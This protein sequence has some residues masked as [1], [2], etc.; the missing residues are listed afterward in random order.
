MLLTLAVLNR[1]VAGEVSVV[2]RRWTKPTVKEGGRLR[3]AVGELSI[4]GV[5]TVE[6]ASISDADAVLAGWTSAVE[7]VGDLFRERKAS[8]ARGRGAK[9]GGVRSIYWI[10]VS[11]AGADQRFD[12]RADDQLSDDELA[13]IVK[14]LDGH[15][16][17]SSFGPWTRHTLSLIHEFPARRAPELAEMHGRETIPFK[18]DV[19]KLKEMGLTESLSVGYQLSPRGKRV[20]ATLISS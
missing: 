15:D 12:L 17:R 20:F 7:L 6:V 8:A 1:I 19:R 2:Y 18:A 4:G 11:F 5:Q 10:E 14:K 3:T 13:A 9:P 16:A